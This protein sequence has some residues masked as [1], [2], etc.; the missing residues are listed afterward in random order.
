M[1]NG[2]R[3]GMEI[4]VASPKGYEPNAQITEQA[5]AF[6]KVTITNDPAEAVAGADAMR[7]NV[8]GCCLTAALA[9]GFSG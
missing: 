1:L 7:N 9:A 6:G 5:R 2:T 8:T 3:L 4:A